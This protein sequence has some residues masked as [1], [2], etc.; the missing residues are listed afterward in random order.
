MAATATAYATK[1]FIDDWSLLYYVLC[2]FRTRTDRSALPPLSQCESLVQALKHRLASASKTDISHRTNGRRRV[3]PC[4]LRGCCVLQCV[5]RYHRASPRVGLH[6]PRSIH[7][8]RTN[9]RGCVGPGEHR[10]CCLLQVWHLDP[11]LGVGGRSERLFRLGAEGSCWAAEED[12][13]TKG[14]STCIV[15]K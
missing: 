3:D 14:G 15:N 4:A 1:E 10:G 12:L 2:M 5:Q 13:T 7:S 11:P 8:H 6:P 9:G